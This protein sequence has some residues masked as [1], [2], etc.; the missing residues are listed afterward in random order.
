MLFRHLI[1][2]YPNQLLGVHFDFR[3]VLN[4]GHC[5]FARRPVDIWWKRHFRQ[6]RD[7]RSLD[8]A[9]DEYEP[10]HVPCRTLELELERRRIE[11]PSH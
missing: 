6:D 9:E 4:A 8:A 7:P 5:L 2:E 3:D 1:T 10:S 11:S